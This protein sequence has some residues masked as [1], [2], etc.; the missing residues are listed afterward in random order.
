M[1][2][3]S[4]F[5]LCIC[6]PILFLSTSRLWIRASQHLVG[7]RYSLQEALD[8][9]SI[10]GKGWFR[11]CDFDSFTFYFSLSLSVVFPF[12]LFCYQCLIRIRADWKYSPSSNKISSCRSLFFA[13]KETHKHHHNIWLP[14]FGK[15]MGVVLRPMNA[16]LCSKYSSQSPWYPPWLGQNLQEQKIRIDRLPYDW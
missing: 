5:E 4:G 11:I 15:V 8:L 9:K 2:L 7:L 3:W 12:C 1:H 10:V 6:D 16:V 13:V 14:M